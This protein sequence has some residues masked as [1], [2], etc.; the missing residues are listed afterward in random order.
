M[1]R[2]ESRKGPGSGR[3]CKT[4]LEKRKIIRWGWWKSLET[5]LTFPTISPEPAALARVCSTTY[6]QRYQVRGRKKAGVSERG[7]QKVRNRRAKESK[8]A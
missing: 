7:Q 3:G 5:M 1:F 8:G 4:A 6:V 2:A